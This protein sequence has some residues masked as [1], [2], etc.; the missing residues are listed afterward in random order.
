MNKIIKNW[1]EGE[2]IVKG[3]Y[4]TN[5]GT[6]CTW[7]EIK[8]QIDQIPDEYLDQNAFMDGRPIL[9][10]PEGKKQAIWNFILNFIT[11][12]T[13]VLFAICVVYWFVHIVFRF[14]KP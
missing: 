9:I 11:S 8:N 12:T 6:P 3:I 10:T 7:K 4:S 5:K 2:L 1:W 13:M 14:I